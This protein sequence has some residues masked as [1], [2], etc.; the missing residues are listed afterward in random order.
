MSEEELEQMRER[1]QQQVQERLSE[2]QI[3][4]FRERLQAVEG[5]EG[6]TGQAIQLREGLSVTVSIILEERIN[7]LLVPN[8]V[9][10]A[11][12]G[13][14]FVQVIKDGVTEQRPVCTGLSGWQNTEIIEGLSEGEQ[15]VIPQK[16]ST[17]TTQQSSQPRGMFG[18]R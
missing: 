9:I 13:E 4:Q 1:F 6:A 14:T 16:T 5:Q 15:V 2:E 3:Q 8:K 17:P 12:G 10:I 7:V 11:Q 18:G